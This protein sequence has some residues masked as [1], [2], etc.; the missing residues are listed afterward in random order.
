MAAQIDQLAAAALAGDAI[1][2]RDLYDQMTPRVYALARR[3][4]VSIEDAAEITQETWLRVLKNHEKYDRLRAF[5]PFFTHI[6]MHELM[7]GL[8]PQEITVAGRSTTV[9]AELKAL[10]GTLEEAKAD[11]SG[12]WALQHLMDKGVLAAAQERAFYTTFLASTFRTLRFGLADSHA[13]G[14]ALQVNWLLDAGGFKVGADGTFSLDLAATKAGVTSLTRE[15]MT[16]QATGD[17]A[18]AK[19]LL[20]KQVVVRPEVKRLLE[21]MRDLPVDLEPRYPAAAAQ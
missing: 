4:G 2:W 18:R 6:L 19:A 15:I 12:L 13:K 3:M 5:E 7:H 8:G 17:Y 1:A 16:I 9:R 21:R 10:N 14:M 11:I 20:E